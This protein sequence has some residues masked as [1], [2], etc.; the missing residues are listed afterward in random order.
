MLTPHTAFPV[1]FGYEPHLQAQLNGRNIRQMSISIRGVLT[2]FVLTV[3]AIGG[4]ARASNAAPLPQTTQASPTAPTAPPA[5]AAPADAA[6]APLG[7]PSMTGPL[8]AAAPNMFDAGPFGKLAVNGILSGFGV[9]QNNP[10]ST[11]SGGTADISNGQSF[12]QKPTGVV[13]FYLQAGAYNLPSLGTPILTTK[14]TVSDLYGPL[15]VAYIKLAPKGPFSFQA[16][17]LPTLIGAEYTFTFENANIERGLLWNQENVITRGVQVNYTKKK[18]A[19]SLVWGD[20]F[21]SN[22]WNWLTGALTY[23]FNAENAL[24]F[25]GGGN[26]GQTE[27]STFATP[28]TQNNSAIYDIIYTH[29]AKNWMVQP[30]FQYTHVPVYYGIGVGRATSSQSE[31]II[32]DYTLPHH[33]FVAGRLEYI[34]TTGNVNDGSANLLYGPGSNAMSVTITPTYQ[35]KAFFT[36]GDVSFVHAGSST[37]GDAFGGHGTDTSQVRGML[38]AGFLF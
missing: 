14:D 36:R 10:V 21:Y 8:N 29:T 22:R 12:L 30:Y 4:H 34:S 17:K 7:T 1:I 13:E 32:G 15:P 19:A 20:G 33:L 27:Y 16:G 37:A 18:L 2:A 35:N 24:E 38:E 3:F 11:D 25:V 5:P 31:A 28:A 6:A 9:W 23:T 26:L